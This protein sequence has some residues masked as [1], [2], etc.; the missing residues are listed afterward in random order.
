MSRELK[1]IRRRKAA[2][3]KIDDIWEHSNSSLIVH[4]S[5]E[6][7]YDTEEGKTPRVTS[8]A[9]RNLASGQT[10]SFSIHKIAEQRQLPFD[11]IHKNYDDLEREMLAEFFDFA[12]TH[13][14]FNWIHW[15][16]RDINYGFAALEHRFRVLGGDPVEIL[17]DRKF[18]LARALV[19]IYGLGYIG[20]PRL[21]KLIEKN[22]ITDRGFLTGADEAEAFDNKEYVKL[23]QST[24]RKV[25]I[26]ANIFERTAD[27]SI[28]TNA[29]WLERN[30]AHPK[31][32][33][34]L[35][36]E[37]WAWSLIVMIAIVV[38]LIGRVTEL[39]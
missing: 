39:F 30:A 29:G 34:E 38:G 24:L 9:V 36:R 25:D 2:Q 13:Q 20:H 4:Y 16:M 7:F 5:C 32:I 19:S 33:V 35:I 3:K 15:N 23:H 37:H 10:E 26:L 21:Q 6:S 17:E 27:N 28:R 22:K 1:R 12:R 8:I 14:H 11:E 18:D 31:I